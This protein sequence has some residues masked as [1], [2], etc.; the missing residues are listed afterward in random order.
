MARLGWPSLLISG[1]LGAANL[2]ETS[3]AWASTSLSSIDCPV[4]ISDLGAV[5]CGQ[6]TVPENWE[7]PDT[8]RSIQVSYLVLHATGDRPA[9]DP[10]VWLEGGPGG[11]PFYAVHSYADWLSD[12][13]A[14]R[15][16]VLIAQRGTAFSE[17]LDCYTPAVLPLLEAGG[18]I[19]DFLT[20]FTQLVVAAAIDPQVATTPAE[21]VAQYRQLPRYSSLQQ[22]SQFWRD[23][24][25]DLAQYNSQRSAA[26]VVALVQ[27]LGYDQYNLL[28]VSYGTRLALTVM[29]DF[30]D[31]GIRSV[32]LDS[33][34]PPNIDS[35]EFTPGL[36]AIAAEQFF[37][38]CETDAAC[39]AA[40]PHLRSTYLALAATLDQTPLTLA[41]SAPEPIIVNADTVAEL[42]GRLNRN[43]QL[44]ATLPLILQEFSQGDGTTYIEQIINAPTE[45]A[46]TDRT[47]PLADPPTTGQPLADQWLAQVYQEIS[48]RRSPGGLYLAEYLLS[49][50]GRHDV[51]QTQTLLLNFL[52]F[53]LSLEA[54]PPASLMSLTM[55]LSQADVD[56]IFSALAI[57][58]LPLPR[59]YGEIAEGMHYAVQ[60]QEE[61]PFED[62]SQAWAYYQALP[63][64]P[65]RR[66][67]DTVASYFAICDG[68]AAGTPD[69]IE[70]AP[71]VS[72]IATLVLAGH[73]DTQTPANWSRLAADTLSNS[74]FVFLPSAGH[75]TLQYSPCAQDLIQ[76]FLTQPDR[77]LNQ[78]C[79][80]ALRPDFLLPQN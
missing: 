78:T 7:Q 42:F 12:I 67:F 26:D 33:V 76:Q 49:L 70:Q 27:A 13:R 32:I 1:V 3:T 63:L 34:E 19:D 75:I 9:A 72:D 65:L 55:E 68:F 57:A 44:A 62:L 39:H 59:F 20:V 73:Y 48:D 31:S 58:D 22:C 36:A 40:F 30:P 25:V 17:A 54:P 18:S 10:V 77:P 47:P 79:V 69:A 80:P 66:P 51:P 5:S 52:N 6:L 71:V 74:Q 61:V 64:V 14:E 56:A 23:R 50:M 41:S 60:C 46:P 21:Y 11:S 43:P 28:G 53:G 2:P 24:G 37:T 29:R 45:A 38:D 16:V 4:D 35:N 15:D 8:S